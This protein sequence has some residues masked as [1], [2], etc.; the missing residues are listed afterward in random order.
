[1]EIDKEFI[2]MLS[3][4]AVQVFTVRRDDI[5][6]ER[7][8]EIS[9]NAKLVDYSH[10]SHHE[11]DPAKD[12]ELF[13]LTTDNTVLHFKLAASRNA[14]ASSSPAPAPD[15]LSSLHSEIYFSL[16]LKS[17]FTCPKESLRIKALSDGEVVLLGLDNSLSNLATAA[18]VKDSDDSSDIVKLGVCPT[19]CLEGLEP[20]NSE[21]HVMK[22]V[23]VGDI[24]GL[25]R[26]YL[27]QGRS[28]K[29]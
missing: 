11:D 9:L 23:A 22:M 3:E 27:I 2:V 18:G 26:A 24:V 20:K 8:Q 13:I 21:G 1:M 17:S 4:T 25:V 16:I 7:V 6:I 15:Q 19:V 29:V 14:V 12:D 28:L 5:S 10:L